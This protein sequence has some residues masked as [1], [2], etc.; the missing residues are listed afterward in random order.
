[1]EMCFTCPN[2]LSSLGWSIRHAN[3]PGI[4]KY[5]GVWYHVD[6]KCRLLTEFS[7][8]SWLFRII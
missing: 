4:F 8:F 7:N 3:D 2:Y 6:Q 1:M 5:L